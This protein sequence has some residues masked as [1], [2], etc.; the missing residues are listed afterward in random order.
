M[1]KG[2]STFFALLLTVSS[3][4]AAIEYR[5]PQPRVTAT[6]YRAIEEAREQSE[7]QMLLKKGISKEEFHL[8]SITNAVDHKSTHKGSYHVYSGISDHADQEQL[9]DGSLWFVFPAERYKVLEWVAG[10]PIAILKGDKN[11]NYRYRLHNE[12]TNQIIEV[13]L[14]A[15][16]HLDS[17][18]LLTIRDIDKDGRYLLLSDGSKWKLPTNW[19]EQEVWMK[20]YIGDI[21]IIGTNDQFFYSLLR[22]DIL[23]NITCSATYT[24]SKCVN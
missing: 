22:P 19:F 15:S 23:I 9:E 17:F 7:Q 10:H 13:E 1:K 20:W 4:Q 18:Y 24:P 14:S 12:A 21:I 8:T 2:L 11:S 16:P 3:L 5:E 6:E